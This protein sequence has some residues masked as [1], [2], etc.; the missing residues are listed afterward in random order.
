[1]IL[2]VIING[3][4]NTLRIQKHLGSFCRYFQHVSQRIGFSLEY[5]KLSI[6]NLASL[7][8]TICMKQRL[9]RDQHWRT[10]RLG[11]L[12]SSTVFTYSS[13]NSSSPS[14]TSGGVGVSS[15]SSTCL[16]SSEDFGAEA[17][18]VRE[19]AVEGDT[20]V[21]GAL[22]VVGV[23]VVVVV[24]VV[25]LVVVVDRALKFFL[26]VVEGDLVVL[27]APEAPER[28]PF[29]KVSPV[30]LLMK[31]ISPSTHHSSTKAVAD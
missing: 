28:R 23:V 13:E 16:S 21:V 6:S 14:G 8:L 18:V 17:E 31:K 5:K 24:V 26:V 27:L 19:V 1:M 9:N 4:I 11:T 20:V 7:P 29:W 25:V 10:F 3:E 15:I 30:T 12:S 2:G 22:G